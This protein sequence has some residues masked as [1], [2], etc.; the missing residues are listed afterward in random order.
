MK[1]TY[2]LSEA[3]I[4]TVREEVEAGAASS[5][6]AFVELAITQLARLLQEQREASMWRASLHDPEF[7]SE[8]DALDREFA[9]ADS[10]VAE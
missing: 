7:T 10:V 2:N 1:R 9:R 5:Q 3:A 6:D 8:M 4:L